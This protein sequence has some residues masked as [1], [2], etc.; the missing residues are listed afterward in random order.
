MRSLYLSLLFSAI[1][2]AL[3]GAMPSEA[4]AQRGRS[5]SMMAPVMAPRLVTPVF[6]AASHMNMMVP[7]PVTPV[8]PVASHMNMNH[9]NMNMMMQ[10]DSMHMHT[11]NRAFDDILLGNLL[12]GRFVTPF[13]FYNPYLTGFYNPYLT[14]FYNPYLTYTGSY[15]PSTPAYYSS[16]V[17]M[18]IPYTALPSSSYA[19]SATLT[20]TN[21]YLGQATTSNSYAANPYLESLA[22]PSSTQTTPAAAKIVDVGIFDDYF[23]PATYSVNVGTTV[24]WINR[25]STHHTVTAD[26]GLWDSGELAPGSV[27]SY[28][29]TQPGIYTY[30][31]ALQAQ[32]MRGTIIVP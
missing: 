26:S 27:N 7:R 18:P 25:G 14:G 1:A 9:M 17:A 6:P 16:Y 32:T 10:R 19:P 28:T 30:H 15:N 23:E 11:P 5:M 4:K 2:S 22:L 12:F 24:R 29:F 20:N 3:L 13:G 31:S 21:P 8:V